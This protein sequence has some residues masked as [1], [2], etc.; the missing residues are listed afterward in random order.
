MMRYLLVVSAL[1]TAPTSLAFQPAGLGERQQSKLYSLS[2]RDWAAGVTAASVGVLLGSNPQ[3]AGAIGPIKINLLNPTYSAIPCPKD[4][5]VPGEK[6]MMGMKPMCVTVDVDLEESPEKPLDKIGVYGFVTD[7][8]TGESVLANNP[9]LSTDAG[10]F[11]MI[12]VVK[13]SDKKTQ[14]EFIAAV[15]R[16]MVS[17]SLLF[18]WLVVM[19]IGADFSF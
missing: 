1:L 17:R 18:V 15:P 5:P 3:P 14:F 6:A 19:I 8:A 11:A 2:R 4:K 16:N 12:P 13:T 9:D 7:T 10:Q